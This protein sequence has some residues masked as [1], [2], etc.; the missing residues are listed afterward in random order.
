M[1]YNWR[2]V[3][4][5]LTM[6]SVVFEQAEKND[7]AITEHLGRLEAAGTTTLLFITPTSIV[8]A[9]V[10]AS[11]QQVVNETWTWLVFTKDSQPFKCLKCAGEMIEQF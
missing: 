10:L 2:Q 5:N 3:F 9:Y 8:E 6:V 4:Q 11:Q 1:S 7:E